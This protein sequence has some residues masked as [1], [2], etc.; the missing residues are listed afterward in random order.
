MENVNINEETPEIYSLSIKNPLISDSTLDEIELSLPV[1]PNSKQWKCKIDDKWKVIIGITTLI[2]LLLSFVL[3]VV[4]LTEKEN[5]GII[6]VYS[7][8]NGSSQ[9]GRK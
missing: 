2:L 4:M 9:V 3:V 7:K 8:K 5:E 1:I 6:F